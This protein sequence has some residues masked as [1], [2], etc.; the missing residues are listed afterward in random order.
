M[1]HVHWS[2]PSF[3]AAAVAACV[4]VLAAPV[5]QAAAQQPTSPAPGS[6]PNIGGGEA[7]AT[8]VAAPSIGISGMG[9]SC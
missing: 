7:R 5:R 9:T 3:V 4:A 2:T 6:I 8:P 1:R